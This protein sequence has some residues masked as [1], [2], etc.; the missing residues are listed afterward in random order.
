MLQKRYQL[1]SERE[2][3]DLFGRGFAAALA[4]L[5]PGEHWQG[6]IESAYG[7]H[8]IKLHKVAAAE[9]EPFEQVRE[10]V[11]ADARQAAREAANAAFYDDLRKR[12]RVRVE[13]GE[14]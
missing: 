9:T 11:Q 5:V 1:R 4:Q 13:Q 7:W 2:I 8:P 6:P 12:Y 3:G 10:R 14:G